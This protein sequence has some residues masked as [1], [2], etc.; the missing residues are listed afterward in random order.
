MATQTNGPHANG[1]N[2]TNGVNGHGPSAV[3]DLK[4]FLDQEYDFVIVGGGTAG[5]AIASRLTENPD[6]K[7]GVLEAGSDRRGDPLIDTPVAFLQ[8][9]GNPDYDWV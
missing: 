7:V 6:V 2:G 9:F 8:M 5:L 4:T 1:V 3:C